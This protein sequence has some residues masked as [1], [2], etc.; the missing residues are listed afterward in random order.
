MEIGKAS[1]NN[2]VKVAVIYMVFQMEGNE[3]AQ[4]SLSSVS[5]ICFTP[6]DIAP[7]YCSWYWY[8]ADPSGLDVEL[9]NSSELLLQ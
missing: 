2:H 8:K 1:I 5:F 4:N 7:L 3:T 9:W 6:N